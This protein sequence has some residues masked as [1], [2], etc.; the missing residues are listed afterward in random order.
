[1]GSDERVYECFNILTISLRA[2]L[3]TSNS[4]EEGTNIH[5]D[6]LYNSQAREAHNESMDK[7]HLIYLSHNSSRMGSSLYRT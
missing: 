2:T 5:I 6:V 7:A 1:M 3:M 4:K